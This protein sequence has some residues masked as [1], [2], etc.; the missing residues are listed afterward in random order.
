MYERNVRVSLSLLHAHIRFIKSILHVAY[1]LSIKKW[2]VL[3][4]TE[5]KHIVKDIK[6]QIQNEFRKKQKNFFIGLQLR[7]EQIITVYY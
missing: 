4:F 3:I 7:I 5:E 2:N 6:S 1:R